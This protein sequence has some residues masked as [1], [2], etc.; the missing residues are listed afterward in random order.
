[1][2]QLQIEYVDID[3]LKPYKQNARKHSEQQIAEIAD[4]IKLYGFNTPIAISSDYTIIAGHGRLEA[5]KL[6]GETVVPVVRLAHL[7]VDVLRRGYTI[8]DNKLALKS[9]WDLDILRIEFEEL[10]GL[11]FDPKQTYFS[12]AEIEEI[13]NPEVD[14][15]YDDDGFEQDGVPEVVVSKP[16]DIWLLGD[17]RLCCGDSTNDT[18]V[19]NLFGTLKPTLMVTDPPYGVKYDPEWRDG[20]DLGVGDKSRGKVLNDD[21]VDWTDAYKL[22]PGNVAYVWHSG[23]FTHIVAQN[24][25]SCDFELVSQI[26]WAKQ[27]FA[28]S[29]GDYHWQHESCWYAVR[30]GC[31]HNWQG[32]RDQATLWEIKNNNSFGN[33]DKEETF[34]H[35]TQKPLECMLRPIMNNSKPGDVV[36]DPFCGSGTTLMACEK[37]ERICVAMELDPKYVDM[38]I[39][40]FL[41]ISKLP[42]ILEATG[43]NFKDLYAKAVR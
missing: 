32:K 10:T 17:H 3:L 15:A 14:V 9:D 27:H 16:G 41:K 2:D 12:A 11:D 28:L 25:N 30:K 31:K 37:A 36:Y 38:I 40:R 19:Q 33:S 18:H 21:R 20:A 35:G 5:L 13:L 7:D 34:G 23:K 39:N 42:A 29:R 1:M 6:L 26:I 8:A 22:F 4:S 24:L 43:E